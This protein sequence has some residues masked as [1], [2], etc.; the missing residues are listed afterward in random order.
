MKRPDFLDSKREKLLARM[1]VLA[2]EQLDYTWDEVARFY[3]DD[4]PEFVRDSDF[5]S[6]ASWLLYCEK[7]RGVYGAGLYKNMY[8]TGLL[9]ANFADQRNEWRRQ[10]QGMLDN[11]QG[12]GEA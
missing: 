9:A 7:M 12:E 6:P 11:N 8:D 5:A 4:A 10:V 3:A 2:E 1:K